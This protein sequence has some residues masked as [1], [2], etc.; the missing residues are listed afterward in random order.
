MTQLAL[1]AAP[2]QLMP[3]LQGQHEGANS[4]A[5]LEIECCQRPGQGAAAT[6]LPMPKSA[7]QMQRLSSSEPC[8]GQQ[9]SLR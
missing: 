2:R 9:T 1:S 3:S 4:D 6:E 8:T 5:N 7:V